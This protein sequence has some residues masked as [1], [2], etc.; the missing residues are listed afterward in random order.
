MRKATPERT[1]TH[2]TQLVLKTIYD[3]GEISRADISRSTHLTR[4]TVSTVVSELMDRGL[5]Q[6]VGYAP[7]SGGQRPLLLSVVNDS[8]HL[9]KG[10]LAS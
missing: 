3:S 4:P 6:E 7:S 1:R 9:K 5:I 10:T 2:N 8:W